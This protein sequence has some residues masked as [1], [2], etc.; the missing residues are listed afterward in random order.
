L[1]AFDSVWPTW[2][3]EM[4]IMMQFWEE[5]QEKSWTGEDLLTKVELGI[6]EGFVSI[7][8]GI[9]TMDWSAL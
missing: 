6:K 9:R 1:E 7:E 4:G 3:Y 8:E 5:F 2:G